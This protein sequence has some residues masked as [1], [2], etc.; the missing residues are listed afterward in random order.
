MNSVARRYANATR[1]TASP[2]RLMVLLFQAAL[3]NMRN[4]TAALEAGRSHEG[5]TALS[6]AAEIVIELHA[7]LDRSKAPELCDNLAELYR[8]VCLRLNTAALSRDVGPAREAEKAFAPIAD[9]F[10]K[11]V[12]SLA[13]N[14]A[15][16]R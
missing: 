13:V 3:R 11:A 9:A 5:A 10:E 6:K 12:A 1:E 14:L 15:G 7:S 16:A 2:E 8:F 4:G